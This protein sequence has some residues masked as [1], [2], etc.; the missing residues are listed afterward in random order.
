MPATVRNEYTNNN[1]WETKFFPRSLVLTI[2]IK[3]WLS[4]CCYPSY[5]FQHNNADVKLWFGKL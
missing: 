4:Q 5:I 3:E 2:E 1:S